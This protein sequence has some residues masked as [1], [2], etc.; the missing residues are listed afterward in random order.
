MDA[1]GRKGGRGRGLSIGQGTRVASNGGLQPIR[2][3]GIAGGFQIAARGTTGRKNLKKVFRQAAKNKTSH[4][5][6][7]AHSGGISA[8]P[9]TVTPEI[10]QGFI[11]AAYEAELNR[12]SGAIAAAEADPTKTPAERAAAVRALRSQQQASAAAARRAALDAEKARVKAVRER[13][14]G[15]KGKGKS[16][17]QHQ[18]RPS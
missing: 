15:G 3:E 9:L 12:F 4:G 16:G 13:E 8:E 1:Q 10:D 18:P 14:K 17:G 7:L 11:N 5:A 2:A 6:K